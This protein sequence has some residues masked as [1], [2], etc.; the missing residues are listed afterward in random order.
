MR[1]RGIAKAVLGAA[2][3]FLPAG[4]AAEAQTL[5]AVKS[6]GFVN[7]GSPNGTPGFSLPD[8]TGEWSGLNVDYCRALA[9]AVFDATGIRIR[10]LP[11]TADQLLG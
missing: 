11:I 6:R 4:G 2:L 10:T 9:A 7:C 3:L 5:A 8:R 1:Q